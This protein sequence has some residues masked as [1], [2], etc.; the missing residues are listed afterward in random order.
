MG[1]DR[2]VISVF[3]KFRRHFPLLFFKLAA[4]YFSIFYILSILYSLLFPL[5]GLLF[6]LFY[7]ISQFVCYIL[8]H[9][10]LQCNP[11]CVYSKVKVWFVEGVTV[12]YITSLPTSPQWSVVSFGIIHI[13]S[14]LIFVDVS[15]NPCD[16]NPCHNNGKC[17]KK[18]QTTYT[19]ECQYGYTGLR[20]EGKCKQQ[21]ATYMA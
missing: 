14:V 13:Y 11:H 20:C 8:V 19:C 6:V 2:S 16:T 5:C 7:S 21:T 15:T 9:F 3:F 17:I 18:S 4:N 1:L 10:S 12:T